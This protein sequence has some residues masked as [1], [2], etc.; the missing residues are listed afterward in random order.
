[1]DVPRLDA[2]ALNCLSV[3]VRESSV[4][5]AGAALGL[6]QPATS[7]VLARLRV[8]F[9]DPILVK[10]GTGMVP[11]PRALELAARAEQVLQQ[12][13]DMLA[14]D[15]QLEPSKLEGTVA[16]AAMDLVRMLLVPGLVQL[17]QTEAPGLSIAV[18]DV[19]RTR[20]HER[21]EHADIDLGIGP[22]IV[23]LERLHYR[24]LWHDAAACLVRE[25]H[26][27]LDEPMT[28][29]R[30]AELGHIRVVPSRA[31]FYDDA[32]EKA[33]SARGLKR[34]VQVSER[35]FLMVPRILDTTDLV[36]IVPR[37]FAADACQR[38]PLCAFEPPFALPQLAMGMYWHER[39]HRDP[40]FQWLRQRV[41]IVLSSGHG[42]SGAS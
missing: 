29:E 38:H 36:A 11:T 42:Y 14:A 4:T 30:L 7:A 15:Q 13:R 12:L 20:I 33:M 27:V 18:H 40:T 19:D 2:S 1:M 39:T 10:S 8:L 22:Q 34:R 37:R 5:R 35:S 6:S 28:P 17:L 21:F 26:P 31:S 9:Q 23:T 16:I 3:L 32:L 25:G 41:A 24:D